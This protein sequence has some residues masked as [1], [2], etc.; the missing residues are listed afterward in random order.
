MKRIILILLLFTVCA[1]T[2]ATAKPRHQPKPPAKQQFVY[3]LRLTPH[4]LDE[5]NW[6]PNDNAA[7]QRHFARLQQMLKD[8]TLIFAG[9]TT[10]KEPM[11]LV[12]FLAANE[13]EARAIM[14]GDDAVKAGIMTAELHPFTVAL[15]KSTPS[16]KGRK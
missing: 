7:A 15:I 14:E 3:V 8:G 6:T 13:T 10:T 11:G 4:Y 1:P 9:R 2:W 16:R 12:V 5:K